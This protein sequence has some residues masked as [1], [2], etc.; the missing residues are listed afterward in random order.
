MFQTIVTIL[1]LFV[2]AGAIFVVLRA[3][4]TGKAVPLWQ[5]EAP[6]FDRKSEPS[7]YWGFV[8]LWTVLAGA[9]IYIALE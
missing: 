7:K 4:I 6:R 2:A 9:M 8:V 5:P 1:E 3:L